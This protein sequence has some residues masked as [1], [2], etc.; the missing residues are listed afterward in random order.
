MEGPTFK[1]SKAQ[2]ISQDAKERRARIG[3]C[4]WRWSKVECSPTGGK[5]GVFGSS[6][7]RNRVAT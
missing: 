5:E 7:V 4:P 6:P 2:I 1:A 3:S